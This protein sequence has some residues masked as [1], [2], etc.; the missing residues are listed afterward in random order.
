MS[1]LKHTPEP[2]ETHNVYGSIAPGINSKKGDCVLVWKHKNDAFDTGLYGNL[3]QTQANA[4][5]IVA[6]VNACAGKP[7]P[8]R[9]IK[10]AESMLQKI[11]DFEHPELKLGES[12]LEFILKLA[13]ERDNL[14][15]ALIYLVNCNTVKSMNSDITDA[16]SKARAVID[17]SRGGQP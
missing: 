16:V 2:W 11:Y 8:E 7:N 9:W 5:R 17:K 1:E 12:K 4:D 6:C 14:L 3:E 10:E 13:A 15:N